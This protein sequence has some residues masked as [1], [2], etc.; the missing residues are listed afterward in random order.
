MTGRTFQ[1]I[2]IA[3]TLSIVIPL[4]AFVIKRHGQPRQNR[5]LVLSLYLS[6]I[7][8]IIGFILSYQHKHTA[9]AFN[10]YYFLA[11]PLIMLF[12][13]ETLSQRFMKILIRVFMGIFVLLAVIF[14]L[15]QGLLVNNYNTW[16]FSSVLITITSFFFVWDLSLMDHSNFTNNKF[17]LPNMVLNTSLAF[18]YFA[19]TV[20]FLMSDY[21]FSHFSDDDIRYFWSFHN[22]VHILKNFGIAIAIVLSANVMKRETKFP[23][24]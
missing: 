3:S 21:I 12:Y 9:L 24:N 20:F 22:G 16:T 23:G 7:F 6:L 17:H 10:L 15:K 13:H 2:G 1:W 14:G 19:A 8:D 11:F 5:L 18:Y 4:I